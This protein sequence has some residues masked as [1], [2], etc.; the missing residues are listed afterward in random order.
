MTGKRPSESRLDAIVAQS[1]RAAEARGHGY[2]EQA[3]KLYPWVCGRCAREFNRLNLSEL[4]VH[5]R[6]HNHDDNPADGSNWELLCVYCHDNEHSRYLDAAY[7]SLDGGAA[8]S[9]PPNNPFANL[10]DLLK[11]G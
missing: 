4:T 1:R 7:G 9:S 10:A 2:R 5:H 3:L 11:K 6:N 8:D